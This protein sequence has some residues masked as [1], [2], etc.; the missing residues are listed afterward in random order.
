MVEKSRSFAASSIQGQAMPQAK[1]KLVIIG[2]GD[3]G[4]LCAVRLSRQFDVTAIT[5]KTS[6]VSGQELGMRLTNPAWWRKHYKISLQRYRR[7]Q[8]V[9]LVHG[10][11]ESIDIVSQHVEVQLAYGEASSV[12]YDYLLIASGASNG[13]WRNDRISSDDEIEAGIET[14]AERLRNARKIDV[15]GGGPSAVSVA[16]NTARQFPE[17]TVALHFSGQK[18]LRGYHALTQDYYAHALEQA[19]VKVHPNRRALLA[20]HQID[21]LGSGQ[22]TFGDGAVVE[23]DAIVWA[24]GR[25][26]PHS[27]FLPDELLDEQ[28]FVVTDLTLQVSGQNNLFAIGD[29]AAT[30]PLR[31]SA[32]NWAYRVLAHNLGRCAKGKEPNRM[33]RPPSHRWGSVVG[34]QD[35][36]LRIH[37]QSG[38]IQRLTRRLVDR[39]LL[40]LVVRRII[41]RGVD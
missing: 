21:Q 38:G 6:L 13:F 1:Q 37:S 12:P 7:L 5:T 33:F 28:G 15:V 23:S 41:Y 39:L 31:S 19:G 36:G 32:R 24:I 8:G 18:L 2:M 3:T 14:N 11:A 40:P 29:V 25:M 4:V 9:R 16:L 34:P 27:D 22:L 30:D 35:D 17:S 10:R 20:D 26:R